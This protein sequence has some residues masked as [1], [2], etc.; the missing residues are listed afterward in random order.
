MIERPEGRLAQGR[1][2]ASP[3]TVGAVAAVPLV[4][5]AV[6]VAVRIRRT[7]AARRG[8]ASSRRGASLR[9]PPAV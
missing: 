6:L 4:V 1:F 7:L 9:P 8:P 5:L 3:W 2:A